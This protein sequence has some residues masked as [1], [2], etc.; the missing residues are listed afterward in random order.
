[1]TPSK[2][3]IQVDR[4]WRKSLVHSIAYSGQSIFSI[5]Y[6]IRSC[7]IP[8]KVPYT[9]IVNGTAFGLLW[10]SHFSSWMIH[11]TRSLLDMKGIPLENNA[12][13]STS[14]RKLYATC[15]ANILSRSMLGENSIAIVHQPLAV[16]MSRLDLRKWI[17]FVSL[18]TFWTP[19][20]RLGPSLTA[21][22]SQIVDGRTTYWKESRSS[23][24]IRGSV[25]SV[26]PVLP[27]SAS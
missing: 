12:S 16:L 25:Y 15:F 8:L 23:C 14:D 20:S 11:D 19:F 22:T 17:T 27:N 18:N 7:I 6:S 13:K 9:P 21:L 24:L 3:Q 4:P 2:F 26:L 1:M 5:L 10:V